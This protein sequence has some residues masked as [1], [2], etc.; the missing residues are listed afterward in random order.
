MRVLPAYPLFVKDPNFSLWSRTDCL[1]ESHP[2]SWFGE[3][4][5]I[6][7]FACVNGVTYCF[8]GEYD[9]FL[10]GKCKKAKQISLRVTAYTTE[11]EFEIGRA[12]V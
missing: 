3:D 2:Q 1:N 6:Y 5:P 12:H 4:K 11:Y 9:C 7:G 8:L 10:P